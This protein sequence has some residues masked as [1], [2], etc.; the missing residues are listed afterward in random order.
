MPFRPAYSICPAALALGYRPAGT[1]AET[2][3]EELDW[4]VRE[5]AKLDL[6]DFDD[7]FDYA[8]EDRYLARQ[9]DA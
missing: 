4:L 1:Y 2:V 6:T 8:A 7:A 9:P 5:H 3:G